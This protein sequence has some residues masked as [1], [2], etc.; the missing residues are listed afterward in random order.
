M[1]G[2]A[3]PAFRG[4]MSLDQP[5]ALVKHQ[6]VTRDA[7]LGG[8][9]T[10]SQPARGFRAGLDSVLLG[11]AVGQGRWSLLD[12][13]SGVGT[14]ALVALVHNSGISATLAEQNA[15]MVT[16]AEA[17]IAENGLSD[18]A[19]VVSADVIG[20]AAARRAVGIAD[21]GYDCVIAN[22]PFFADGTLAAD[23]GRADAR[24]MDAAA[25]DS[26]VRSAAAAAAAGG[27]AIFIYPAQS[28]APLLEAFV[29]RFG[30][31]VV[32][33]LL[34]RPGEPASRVLV[35]GI[36]GSRA[37]LTLLASR[38]LHEPAGRSFAPEFEAI[39]RGTARLVW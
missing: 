21:N 8:R 28:L 19:R 3:E 9:L 12:L 30:A 34:P 18:R 25:L 32:L 2:R 38:A 20:P 27:E 23:A 5:N 24:H 35:R 39:F 29:R 14:A 26:W 37:P 4:A 6:S 13:G 36:K 11:A 33:P 17:N 31:I 22:P 1:Y 15:D 10:L 16:L 7:F